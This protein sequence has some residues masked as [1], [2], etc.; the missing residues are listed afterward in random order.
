MIVSASYRTDIPA[1]YGAWFMRRLEAGFC[2][3][4]SPYG[5]PP[6]RVGLS[7][8]E[9]AGF[10]FWT[11]N[12]GPFMASLDELR[13][14]GYPFT[15]QFTLTGYPNAL[16]PGV[17]AP[18][19]ALEQLREV[20]ARFGKRVAVWRYD[21]ILVSDLTPFDSHRARFERL[22]DA[23]AG[24]VDEVVISFAQIYRKTKRNLDAAAHAH[25]FSWRDPASEEKCALAAE[26]AARARARGMVL[27][28][29][30][31]PDYLGPGI[32]PARCID[33]RRLADV[34]GC[35]IEVPVKGNRPGCLCAAS[36]DIGAYDSC[37]QG[38]VYCYAVAS[39]AA[40]KRRLA[41]HDPDAEYLIETSG[42]KSLHPNSLPR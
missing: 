42:R 36:R 30:A 11:R 33:P 14:R 18:E 41:G 1:F 32:E 40:A 13:R 24:A 28:L 38:C 35:P 21:P 20:A 34:A 26:L 16:E 22:A 8:D 23:L 17:I 19:R 37:A 31:Q 25:G 15:V 4:S 3:V 9:V 6:A 29:C 10:V 27:S 12:L 2:R 7:R 39:R 5:G